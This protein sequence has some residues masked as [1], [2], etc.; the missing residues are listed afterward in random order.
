MTEEEQ[1][2]LVRAYF[3]AVD[4]GDL[5]GVLATLSLDCKFTVETHGI[6]LNGHHELRGMYERLWRNHAAMVHDQMTFVPN[7]GTSRIAAQFRVVNT[8]HDGSTTYKSNCNFFDIEYGRF[9]RVAV[10]M[11]GDTT[12]DH[13]N[14]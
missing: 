4:R 6:E 14:A 1:I 8:E 12:L 2:E 13:A 7:A 3:G 5:E 9:S 10:Y 11:A